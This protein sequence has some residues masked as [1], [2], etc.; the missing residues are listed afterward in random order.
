MSQFYSVHTRHRSNYPHPIRLIQGQTVVLGRIDDDPEGWKNWRYCYTLD[1]GMEGWVPEQI[2]EKNGT[3]GRITENYCAHELDVDEGDTVELF[4]ELNEW[5]WCRMASG[6]DM[7]GF[8]CGTLNR[9]HRT[10]PGKL[11]SRLFQSSVG[12]LF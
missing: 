12:P 6:Q 3:E 1:G 9:W 7:D 11:E 5:G 4:K 2:I 10:Q 8:R